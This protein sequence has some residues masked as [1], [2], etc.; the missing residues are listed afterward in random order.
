MTIFM[1]KVAA[2]VAGQLD[3]DGWMANVLPH[4]KQKKVKELQ[5]RGEFVAMTGDGVNDAPALAAA[6]I[7]IAIGSG[8]DVAAETA[9]IILVNSDPMD[10]VNMISFGKTTY[11]KM[12]ANLAWGIAIPFW[13]EEPRSL[14]LGVGIL[15]GLMWVPLPW[16]IQHWVGLFHGIARTVLIVAAWFLVPEHSFTVIPAVVVLIYAVSIAALLRRPMPQPA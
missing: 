4:D 5:D 11:R 15:A 9:D 14:P 2:A 13:L 3:M 1:A 7:G 6:D 10:V 12:M 8:T 16:M